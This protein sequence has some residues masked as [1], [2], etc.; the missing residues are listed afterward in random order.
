MSHPVLNKK[1][2]NKL[3]LSRYVFIDVYTHNV[4]MTFIRTNKVQKKPMS[5]INHPFDRKRR[6]V[7]S[8]AETICSGPRKFHRHTRVLTANMV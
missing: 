2:H 6:R 8:A 5:L 7:N 4:H 1:K 3:F